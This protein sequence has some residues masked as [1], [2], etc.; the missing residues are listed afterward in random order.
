MDGY[1]FVIPVYR[2]GR[3]CF[4]LVRKILHYEMPV[5]VVDDGNGDE[6]RAWLEKAGNLS[7]LVDIVTLPENGGKGHA[8]YAGFERADEMK[9]SHVMQID[10]D[11]QQ[12]SSRIPSFLEKSEKYPD[13]AVIGYPVYDESVPAWRKHG[14]VFG[15]FFSHLSALDFKSVRDYMCGFRVYP[16]EATLRAI[17][18][19]HLDLRM[20]FDLE[21]LIR[22]QFSGIPMTSLP[23]GMTYPV[24]GYSNVHLF[25]DNV[26]ISFVFVRMLPMTLFHI[27]ALLETRRASRE[28]A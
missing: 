15:N 3:K 13:T 8:M 14:R 9:L 28:R 23:V 27:R 11:G 5:I 24:D 21:I 4:E 19:K 20:G 7:P 12:D 10:A 22:M 1:G 17:R 26:R 6:D 16:V 18:K 25:R 2:H